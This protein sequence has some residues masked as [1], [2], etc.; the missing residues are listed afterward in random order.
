[1]RKRRLARLAFGAFHSRHPLRLDEDGL[2]R[3]RIRLETPVTPKDWPAY[4]EA[5]SRY[6]QP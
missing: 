5:A 3:V 2:P 4:R 6:L 1:M